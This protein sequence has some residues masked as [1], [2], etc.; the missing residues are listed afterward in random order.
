M[1]P[2]PEAETYQTKAD[3]IAF[4]LYS[5]GSTGRSKGVPHRHIDMIHVGDHFGKQVLKVWD[6]DTVFSVSKLFFAYGLGNGF[7]IPFRCGA[8][9]VLLISAPS[10]ESVVETVSTYKPTMF[11]GVPTQYNS[12]LR[13]M[14]KSDCFASV[15]VCTSAG[16]A[17]P[18]VFPV[19]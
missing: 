9:T 5:S 17:L 11:F 1:A 12:V 4:R 16:E 19:M 18:P 6:T 10:P 15:R 3:D 13:R 2:V 14:K 8:S 7:H